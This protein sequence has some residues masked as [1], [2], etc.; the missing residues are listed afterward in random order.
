MLRP[1]FSVLFSV[2]LERVQPGKIYNL[3]EYQTLLDVLGIVSNAF[4]SRLKVTSRLE[5]RSC[6]LHHHFTI[7]MPEDFWKGTCCLGEY[8][9]TEHSK[10][11]F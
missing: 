11:R 2:S 3:G 10:P 1:A 4:S 9:A 6:M 5:V 7:G 8:P